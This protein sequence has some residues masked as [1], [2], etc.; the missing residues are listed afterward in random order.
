MFESLRNAAIQWNQRT[1]DRQ[2]L[3]HLYIV[4]VVVIVFAAGLISLISGSRFD[5]LMTIALVLITT[6][7]VNFVAWSLLKT[8]VLDKLPRTTARPAR[9]TSKR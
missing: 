2:K 9:R 6:F 1:T 3:Q 4:L 7:A 8:A 5:L